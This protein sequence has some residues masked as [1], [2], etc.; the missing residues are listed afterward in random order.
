MMRRNVKAS[1]IWMRVLVE[2]G[3]RFCDVPE[4][5]AISLLE[6]S[7]WVGLSCTMITTRC[8][9]RTHACEELLSL[10]GCRR[11]LVFR[12]RIILVW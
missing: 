9:R 2:E 11:L 12:V 8:G 10:D 1:L 7:R 6:K 5:A 3:A 4:N